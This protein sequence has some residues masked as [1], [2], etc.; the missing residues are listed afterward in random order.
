MQVGAT[1]QQAASFLTI[2]TFRCHKVRLDL[3]DVARDPSL[4]FS[5]L[6]FWDRWLLWLR[7]EG[8]KQALDIAR[9]DNYDESTGRYLQANGNLLPPNFYDLDDL[10]ADGKRGEYYDPS[11][12]R[13]PTNPDYDPSPRPSMG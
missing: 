10:D 3:A 12:T 9:A 13:F 4:G 2:P 5:S 7:P 11:T 6:D 8:Y 1:L